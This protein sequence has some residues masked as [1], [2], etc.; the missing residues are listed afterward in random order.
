MLRSCLVAAGA[1]ALLAPPA[2]AQGGAGST[3]VGGG[4]RD[5]TAADYPT[6]APDWRPL[7]EAITAA[8]ADSALVLL[9]A[10]ATWCGWCRRLDNDTYTD[11]A[12]QAYL[13]EHFEVSRLDIESPDPV[14]FFGSTVTMRELGQ[15]FEVSGT[16]TTVFLD[17][18]GT[19]ITKAPS[20][21][22]PDKF[23]L[24]LRYVREG[25]YAMMPFTDYVEMIEAEQG[26]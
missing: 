11:D 25:F 12:V 7:G 18:D 8:R 17:A 6:D 26:G 24:V 13:D 16:P 5:S 15:T 10:Y 14:D 9:H 19:F 4:G 21:W 22:P 23:L 2:L 3:I 20:Y 1:L